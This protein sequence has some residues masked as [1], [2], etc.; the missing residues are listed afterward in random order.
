MCPEA[1]PEV[2][3]VALPCF[4]EQVLPERSAVVD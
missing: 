1:L 2:F 4:K 3:P